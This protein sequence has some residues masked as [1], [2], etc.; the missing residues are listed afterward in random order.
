MDFIGVDNFSSK[1]LIFC[2]KRKDKISQ[3]D[4]ITTLFFAG[5]QNHNSSVLFITIHYVIFF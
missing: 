3:I 2:V 1:Y 5:R 4:K